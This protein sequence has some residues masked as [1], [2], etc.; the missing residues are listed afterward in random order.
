[1]KTTKIRGEL[2]IDHDRGVIYFHGDESCIEEFRVQTVL[3]ICRLPTP[4]PSVKRRMLDLA[5]PKCDWLGDLFVLVRVPHRSHRWCDY[6]HNSVDRC[7]TCFVSENEDA[8][9]EPCR[10]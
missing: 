7:S 9:L 4:V 8:A 3:R 5:E 10:A 1:M 2:E 6:G